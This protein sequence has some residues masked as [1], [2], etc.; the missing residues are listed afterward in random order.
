MGIRFVVA[1]L[2]ALLLAPAAQAAD[3]AWTR[4]AKAAR[5]ALERSTDAGYL[6]AQDRERYLRIMRHA[7]AVR[8]R[9]PPLR[10]QLLDE[11]LARVAALKSPTAARALTLYGALSEN[12]DYLDRNRVPAD[13][14]DVTGSDG[15][16]Y[17]FFAGEG[18]AFHPLANAAQLNAL[19][20]GG[21]TDEARALASALAE[22]TTVQDG[23]AVW[24]YQFD[25]GAVHAPWTSGMAQAVLAQALARAGHDEL[26]RMAFLAIPG[27]LDRKLSAG[28]W[29]RLYSSGGEIVLNAQLQSA[30]SIGEYAELTGDAEAA[31]YSSRL[32]ATAKAMLPRFDTGHWSRYSLGTDS[33]LHYQGYVI[34]LLKALGKR[35]GDAAWSDAAKRFQHYETQPP[36]MTR[37]SV[38]GVVVPHPQDGVRDA[39]VVRFWLSKPSRVALVVDGKAVDGYTWS[40]GWHAFRWT[41]LHLAPGTHEARLVARSPDGNPGETALPSFS[42]ER[43]TTPPELAAAKSAGRVFWSAKDDESAC[44]KLRLE[45]RRGTERRVIALEHTKGAATIPNG[46]WLVT[47]VARDAAGNG[48]S[49]ELGLVVGH[50]SARASR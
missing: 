39:L 26:A 3:E 7:R 19:V 38:T 11:V 48:A 17:R 46:Y 41:P 27:R 43:D 18:F 40:G 25:F 9:V 36:L 23:A 45:L 5:T 29:I 31:D 16:V 21:K 34:D 8:D 6:S 49:R 35:T 20:A 10:A 37:P 33:S 13:G 44:C 2:V 14:T 24:E 12:A 32:L 28:P 4:E 42:V 47:A 50:A 15:V 30:I 22:R 1:A